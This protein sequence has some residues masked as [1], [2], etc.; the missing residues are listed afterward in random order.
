[1]HF[2]IICFPE[3]NPMRFT[4][5]YSKEAFY[6][7][8]TAPLALWRGHFSSV[9][10]QHASTT[11]GDYN[12][13]QFVS[14]LPHVTSSLAYPTSSAFCVLRG[15]G[16]SIYS[17]PICSLSSW[18]PQTTLPLVPPACQF[19]VLFVFFIPFFHYFL[20]RSSALNVSNPVLSSRNHFHRSF[21]PNNFLCLLPC[22]YPVLSG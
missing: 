12:E 3:M 6:F 14:D 8:P 18:F 2:C 13:L 7:D 9:R 15:R 10:N 4:L 1:M 21:P 16:Y 17:V 11:W 5:S 20:R 22:S 19:H